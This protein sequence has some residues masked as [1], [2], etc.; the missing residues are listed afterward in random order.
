MFWLKETTRRWLCRRTF[1]LGCVL[2]TLG[3]SAWIAWTRLETTRARYEADL[4]AHLGLRAV[5][6]RLSFPRPGV[7]V[8]HDVRLSR[9]DSPACI[10][11]DVTVEVDRTQEITA[12]T[13]DRVVIHVDD[14]LA[15]WR[16]LWQQMERTNCGQLQ[17]V[18]QSL[19]IEG[20][21]RPLPVRLICRLGQSAV[22][23]QLGL[24]LQSSDVQPVELATAAIRRGSAASGDD[25]AVELRSLCDL[26]CELLSVFWPPAKRMGKKCGFQGLIRAEG[27]AD[28]WRVAI[29]KDSLLSQIDLAALT[30]DKRFYGISGVAQ[31]KIDGAQVS[32][33]RLDVASGDFS[34]RPGII[35]RD[36]FE[37]AAKE[38]GLQLG[39]SRDNGLS[40]IEFGSM[41]AAFDVDSTGVQIRGKC[42]EE[43]SG[44]LLADR[45]GRPLAFQKE[46]R[47]VPI[48]ALIRAV[49]PGS[50]EVLPASQQA[51]ELARLLPLPSAEPGNLK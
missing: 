51:A 1:L 30:G 31:L 10:V 18:V 41:E 40:A 29:E 4:S 19:T 27:S 38:L 13:V 14:L 23:Q 28:G 12:I 42:G 6:S 47:K 16:P 37:A 25:T 49:T 8:F 36:V 32:A 9:G 2:P 17:V 5:C 34:V 50:P 24:R 48:S 15:L 21:D 43:N 35:D 46:P 11:R 39:K 26:P 45:S 44:V 3:I 33:G 22:G 7:T 20:I